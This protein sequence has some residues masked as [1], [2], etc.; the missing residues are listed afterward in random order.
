MKQAGFF[1]V[2]FRLRK[3]DS[4][5][6]PLKRLNELIDWEMFRPILN[7]IRE[8]KKATGRRPYD[9]VMMFKVL[10]LQSLYNLSDDVTEV[11]ILDR[12]SFMRFLDIGIG[13]RVPDSKTIWL[14]REKLKGAGIFDELFAQF[15]GFLNENGFAARRGQIIDAS[16]VSVPKQRNSRKENEAIKSGEEISEW[17]EAK[18]RQKDT[19]ARWTKK[20]GKSYYGYKNHVSIDVEHKL[21]RGHHVTDASVHDSQV[22]LEVLDE[23]NSSGAVWADSAYRSR[24]LLFYLYMHGYREHIQRKGNRGKPLTKRERQGNRSRSRIRSR[25]EHVFGVQRQRARTLILHTIGLARAVLKIGLRNLAYN[26]D[27]YSLLASRA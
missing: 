5:G 1:D 20:N 27:R 6:D 9:P 21:I 14:F 3:I 24:S 4:N 13:D 22:M 10:I 26:L 18:R 19:D 15:D 11:Q 12:L 17:S 25:V 2:D 16:I 23:D 8:K 7:K